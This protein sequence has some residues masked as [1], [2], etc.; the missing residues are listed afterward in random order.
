MVSGDP[1]NEGAASIL[2]AVGS[3]L[4]AL[5]GGQAAQVESTL[6]ALQAAPTPAPAPLPSS[7]PRSTLRPRAGQS[8][9]AASPPGYPRPQGRPSTPSAVAPDELIED[10]ELVL[11]DARERA[12]AIID[13]STER[14]RE[15]I[16]QERAAS[17]ASVIDPRAFDDLRSGLRNLVTEVRDIQQRLARIEQ[18][19]RD[20]NER[21]LHQVARAPISNA[22]AEPQYAEPQYAEPQYAEPQYA[23]PQGAE[24]Q[25]AE[26]QYA[27]PQYAEPQDAE[28]QDAEPQGAEPDEYEA[29]SDTEQADDAGYIPAPAPPRSSFSVVP[30]QRREW[31]APDAPDAD[32]PVR[33]IEAAPT[34]TPPAY[35][36]AYEPPQSP[37]RTVVAAAGG[38]APEP[39]VWDDDAQY[40]DPE[41]AGVAHA[42]D[43]GS[44]LVTFLPSDGAIT[45][46]V[47]PVA[48][49]QGLMRVQ[50]ALTRLPAVRTAAVDT[51]SQGEA[52]LHIELADTSDSD[53]IAEGL[54]R[55]LGGTA[56]VED[57]SEVHR[58]LFIT[59]R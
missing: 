59:L 53:E 30:P 33:D 48:G 18:L 4:V 20:Q 22:P 50:E 46:R 7:P 19:I 45:L 40:A 15:L 2:R 49:F 14:A 1:T 3:L 35:E 16:R 51:Y 13:E 43:G 17:G 47:A 9:A 31:G 10:V 5:S 29:E 23:E 11:S 52:R 39:D 28:P 44:P 54:S 34:T 56:R 26:P 55:A 42:S 58:E 37:P 38:L 8:L 57:A 12:Q 36:P 6:N 21:A 32:A 24:P 25:Y 27:E 41:Y